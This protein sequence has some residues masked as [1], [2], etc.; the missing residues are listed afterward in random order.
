MESILAGNVYRLLAK[1]QADKPRSVVVGLASGDEIIEMAKPVQI[2]T[3]VT[4]VHHDFMAEE[5]QQ[6][7]P[8]FVCLGGSAGVVDVVEVVPDRR[9]RRPAVAERLAVDSNRCEIWHR[10]ALRRR[11]YDSL[12]DRERW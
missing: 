1:L 10:L 5:D 12:P 11:R 3:D 9:A 8:Y 2:G 7:I 6:D 4:L